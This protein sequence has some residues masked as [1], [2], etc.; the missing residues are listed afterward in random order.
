MFGWIKKY[1]QQAQQEMDRE[2][3]ITCDED[4]PRSSQWDYEDPDNSDPL[5]A[6][7]IGVDLDGTLARYEPGK[8]LDFIGEP[9]PAM[10]DLVQK[11]IHSQVRVKIFTAR[12]GDPDQLPLIQK[13]LAENGFPELE[14]TNVKD[15]QMIRLYDDRCVQVERNIGRLIRDGSQNDGV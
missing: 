4:A 2:Y 6:P 3:S 11:M 12:A 8:G 13:W 15:Y 5:L 10:V 7:W 14:I 1:F 9:V